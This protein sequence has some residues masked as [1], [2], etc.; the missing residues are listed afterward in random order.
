M[1]RNS[2]HDSKIL[3]TG[4]F[5]AANVPGECMDKVNEQY[6]RAVQHFAN[7]YG[8]ERIQF[9]PAPEEFDHRVHLEKGPHIEGLSNQDLNL[10]GYQVWMRQLVPKMWQMLKGLDVDP[11]HGGFDPSHH[12]A[13]PL[14][15]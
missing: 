8:A 12:R 1:F 14:G 7:R 4:L 15:G 13:G 3:L 2:T 10:E 11:R 9:L 5:Y 6:R